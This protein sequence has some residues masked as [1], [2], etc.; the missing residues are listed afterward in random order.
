MVV[1]FCLLFKN[2]LL[3][4]GRMRFLKIKNPKKTKTLDPFFTYK[5]AK[6]GPVLTL[7]HI[8]MYMYICNGW[9]S[10][11]A[12]LSLS[13]SLSQCS[14]ALS[15]S[16]SLSLYLSLYLSISIYIYIY[17]HA[18]ESITGPSLG[19]FKVN[20]WSKFVFFTKKAFVKKHYKNRGFSTFLK[21]KKR[22]QSFS[23]SITGPSWAFFGPPTWTSYRL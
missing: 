18:V 19:V 11:Q 8:H 5:K 15:L 6:F 10:G 17:M 16:L 2:P 22:T 9:V 7:Q 3:S 13:L 21:I 12:L 20:N 23:K 1:L 4:A 14:L